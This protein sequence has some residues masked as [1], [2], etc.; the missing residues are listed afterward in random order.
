MKTSFFMQCSLW[1][2]SVQASLDFFMLC[3]IWYHKCNL[4]N[5]NNI[6]VIFYIFKIVQMEPNRAKRLIEV[7]F[8]V[9]KIYNG[10]VEI[11]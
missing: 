8:N 3:A 11:K 10:D 1:R 2:L 6:N 9:D 7:L 5:E 4:K